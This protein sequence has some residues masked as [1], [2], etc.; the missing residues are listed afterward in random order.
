MVEYT[1]LAFLYH[2][3]TIQPISFIRNLFVHTRRFIHSNFTTRLVLGEDVGLGSI[4]F[5]LLRSRSRAVS[6]VV[7]LKRFS[8]SLPPLFASGRFAAIFY[9]A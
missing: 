8:Y 5:F 4:K 7:I 2:L 1:G 6:S 9:T 3:V